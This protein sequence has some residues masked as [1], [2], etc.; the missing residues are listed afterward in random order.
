MTFL[1]QS[2]TALD[3]GAQADGGEP[4]QE[5]SEQRP[6]PALRAASPLGSYWSPGDHPSL[7]REG[8]QGPSY[9]QLG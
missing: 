2:L 6:C 4:H 1:V 3:A 9:S 5:L 7:F 8:Q